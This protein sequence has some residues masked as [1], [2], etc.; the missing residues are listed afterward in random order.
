M[1]N[2]VPFDTPSH[3]L[4]KVECNLVKASQALIFDFLVIK[5]A[6]LAWN[7]VKTQDPQGFENWGLWE[8]DVIELFLSRSE[9]NLP[10]LELQLSPFEQKFALVIEEPRKRFYYPQACPFQFESEKSES[11]WKGKILVKFVDIPG[12]SEKIFYQ[13]S[14]CLGPTGKRCYFS[15]IFNEAGKNELDFHQPDLFKRLKC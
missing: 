8:G 3:G 14:A 5:D 1:Q 4:W 7:Q 6:G 11:F 10:Y 15:S 2:L 9:G 13:A 12:A